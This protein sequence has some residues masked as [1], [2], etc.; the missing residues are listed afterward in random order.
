ME[1]NQGID[2]RRHGNEGEEGGRD[3]TD[4]VTE[5][6]QTNGQTAQND[7]EVEP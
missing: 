6:E 5:V 2:H 4:V 7:G 1:R 3:A